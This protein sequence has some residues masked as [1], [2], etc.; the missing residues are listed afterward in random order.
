ML[1]IRGRSLVGKLVSKGMSSGMLA[2]AKIEAAH[3]SSRMGTMRWRPTAGGHR[4]LSG[5]DAN[6]KEGFKIAWIGMGATAAAGGA[7]YAGM[8]FYG[9]TMAD[10]FPEEREIVEIPPDLKIPLPPLGDNM[11]VPKTSRLATTCCLLAVRLVP[12]LAL[13]RLAATPCMIRVLRCLIHPWPIYRNDRRKLPLKLNVE[14]VPEPR[15]RHPMESTPW[16]FRWYVTVKRALHLI[17]VFVPF[18]F[19][20]MAVT[21]FDKDE[22]LREYWLGLM[23]RSLERA[24]CSFMKFGQWLSMRP[25]LF[26]ADVIDALSK[27]RNDAPS[28]SIEHTRQSILTSFGKEIE[29][30]FEYFEVDPVASGTIAQVYKATLREEFAMEGG[31]REVAVKVRHPHVV[32][33]SY[34][35]TRLLFEVLDFMGEMLLN[36]AQPFDKNAFNTAL[37]KQVGPALALSLPKFYPR[38]PKL[39]LPQET[40]QPTRTV[41]RLL[42]CL[43]PPKTRGVLQCS[44][45]QCSQVDLRALRP[46]L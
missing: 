40:C 30:I 39:S 20:S 9:I 44:A 16:W 45:V 25:D 26:P 8:R 2:T 22:G 11:W 3:R 17:T 18:G 4:S 23:V 46:N 35:D 31:V 36:T 38:L 29:E 41:S 12:W 33:E 24:G 28:H 6:K 5:G 19:V 1:A 43:T 14:L 34:V 7:A 42:Y 37:Q 21:I 13:P 15:R 32:Q 27:L 10:I